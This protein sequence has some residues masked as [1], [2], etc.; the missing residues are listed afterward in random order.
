MTANMTLAELAATSLNAIR[1]LERHGLDYCCGGKQPF[2]QACLTKG[3]EPEAILK[4]IDAANAVTAIE[5]DWRTAPL[6]ELVKHIIET[7]H[8]YLK[9][10]LPVL[11]AR[12]EKVVAVH[13]P[14]DPE[15]LPQLAEVFSGLRAELEM[16]LYKEEAIL[17]PFIE[18]Y[19][20]AELRNR[21]LP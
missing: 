21:P 6:D 11:Q 10:D 17:F 1:I 14:R 13:G 8:A 16:H 4:K 9:L 15:R 20:R 19:A 12:M 2:D 5:R 18:Q 7:H 3:L